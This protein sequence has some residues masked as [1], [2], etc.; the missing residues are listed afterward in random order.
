MMTPDYPTVPKRLA[1]D[2]PP[3]EYRPTMLDGTD[4]LEWAMLLETVRRTGNI[5][6]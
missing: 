1:T 5:Q 3:W 2:L 6:R 4:A